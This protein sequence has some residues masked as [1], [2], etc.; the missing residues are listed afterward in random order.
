MITPEKLFQPIK[1]GNME[2]KNRIVMA[3]LGIGFTFATE[4]GSVTDRFIAFYEARAKGGVGLIQLTVAALGRPHATGLV[5]APGMLSII[6]DEHIPSAKRFVEAIHRHGTKVSF[7]ITHHGSATARAVQQRP[8]VEYPELMRV[9]TATGT[10]DPVTGFQTHSMTKEEIQDVTEAFGQA[11]KRGKAAGFDAVRIQGCH[12]YLIRQFLS[13]RTNKRTDEYGGSIENRARF[14]CEIVKRVRK[15]V[16]EGFP[17]IFRMNGDE[18][19]E[20]GITMEEAVEHAKLFVE[21]GVDVLDVSSGPPETSHWQYPIMFQES[22]CLVPSA[23]AIKKAVNV[24][25]MAVGKINVEHGERILQ[26]GLADLIQMGRPLMADPDLAN[27]AKEGKLDDIRPCIFCGHCQAGGP[28]GGYANCSVNMAMGKELEYRIEPAEKKKKIM[29]IGGGPAGMEAARTLAE[30]GHETSLYEQ[31]DKLGGQWRIVANHLP[32]EQSLIDYLSHGMTNAGV[33]LF[34]NR[35]V[36]RE[37]VKEEE[38]DA[39]VIATGSV[40]TSLD[41]PGI[42]GEN[43]IQ[44]T[45][46]LMGKKDTGQDVVVIGG[47]IVGLSAALYLAEQG[48]NVSVITRSNIARGLNGNM[49]KTLIEFLVRD[50]IRLYPKATPDSIS[51]NGVNIWWTTSEEPV[52]DNMFLFLK[53]DTVVLAVG[54]ENDDTLISELEGIVPEIY[55]VGDCTGKRS[56]FAAIRGGSEV[57]R[58]I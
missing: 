9:V 25:V 2:L 34:L 30:R 55:P 50:G 49:K 46:V 51:E 5:F 42:D 15:E 33:N 10:T 4:D 32:E 35:E 41:I 45:D 28:G 53:A 31:N 57:G 14:A 37:T 54:A 6:D 29:V 8:P 12:A 36:T 43:V 52:R 18:H 39:V 48:K 17:I 16:G 47:R 38:P 11:A 56:I 40:P 24:P 26:E 7:Q 1:I 19:L 27:K 22:G 44:A 13:P 3:P 21:A 23:A 58:S 20:G